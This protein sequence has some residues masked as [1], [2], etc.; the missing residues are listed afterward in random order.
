[1]PTRRDDE[2]FF[3]VCMHAE[4]V[5]TTTASVIARLPQDGDDLLRY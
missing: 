4:P 5:G 3:A 2:R 1:V